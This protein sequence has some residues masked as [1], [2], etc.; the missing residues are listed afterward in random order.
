M[1]LGLTGGIATGKST[2]GKKLKELGAKVVD[3][4]KIA[5]KV[6]EPEGKAYQEVVDYFGERILTSAGEID[7][8]KLGEIV[9]A[10]ATERKKL[11]EITHPYIIKT[12]K[13]IIKKEENNYKIV[14]EAPLLYEV[15]LEELVKEVWV[16]SASVTNQIKRL[17]NR[18]GLNRREAIKRIDSQLPLAEKEKRADLVIYNNGTKDELYNKITKAWKDW[19][20]NKG[21]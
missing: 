20:E 2:A 8:K 13:D 21:G 18:D 12:I 6:I 1:S 7:R 4:D 14:L 16:I 11:E 17:Q 3:A 19:V 15:G 5:H 9:F 10:D